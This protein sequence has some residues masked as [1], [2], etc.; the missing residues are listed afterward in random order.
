MTPSAR[1]QG[2]FFAVIFFA[3]LFVAI[4][5]LVF[6]AFLASLF[7]WLALTP[8]DARFL[9][10]IYAFGAFFMLGCLLARRQGEVRGAVQLIGIWTGMLL[11]VSVLNLSAFDFTRPPVLIWFAANII[12]PI[13]AIF[14]TV[15]EPEML[16]FA[17]LPGPKVD[18]WAKW[19]LLV[20]GILITLLAALLFFFPAFMATLWPWEVT[21]VLAQMYAGPLLAYGLGSLIFSRQDKW[22]GI[23]A[24]VP[25]MVIF[26]DATLFISL[27][28]FDV[29]SSNGLATSLWFV[30]FAVATLVLLFMGFTAVQVRE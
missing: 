2:I 29:F 1:A 10:A 23:R 30:W 15:R 17:D 4:V 20:Q 28:H 27:L 16:E 19:F 12:F 26:T 7:T 14:M 21:P 9:G 8:L 6:P 11:I 3:S 5:G 25:G 13:M 22:I 24:I 18:A